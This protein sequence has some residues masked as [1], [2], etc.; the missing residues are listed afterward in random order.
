MS[1]EGADD[2]LF[3]WLFS[4]VT[5]VDPYAG[6][7]SDT[8]QDVFGE[9]SFTG[10]G[11]FEV[12]IF[13]AALGDRFREN[14]LLSHGLLEGSYLRTAL[15]SDVE[16]LDDQPSSYISHCARLHRWVRGDWQ[17]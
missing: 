4:G 17:T 12:D 15:A 7:V 11:I 1:L 3:A 16:V 9:G 14:M 2:S 8:Y 6:A 10:K 5:G 13:N